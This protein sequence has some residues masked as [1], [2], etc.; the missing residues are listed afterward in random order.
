MCAGACA[1]RTAALRVRR[2]WPS[3][4]VASGSLSIETVSPLSRTGSGGSTLLAVA[5]ISIAAGGR[6]T[7]IRSAVD[8]GRVR[9]V[10][11]GAGLYGGEQDGPFA[12]DR[13]VA[14]ALRGLGPPLCSR[15]RQA[16]LQRLHERIKRRSHRGAQPIRGIGSD[17]SRN[18]LLDLYGYGVPVLPLFVEGGRHPA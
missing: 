9:P 12:S 15:V 5:P 2:L 16:L 14:A 3:V 10:A 1:A 8:G 17:C 7:P 18:R 11:Y 13:R 4:R 6:M